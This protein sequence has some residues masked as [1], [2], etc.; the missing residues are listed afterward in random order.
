[1]SNARLNANDYWSCKAE[2]MTLLK[3]MTL[4][5]I[6][7]SI[8]LS[9]PYKF[10]KYEKCY[11]TFQIQT[12]NIQGQCILNSIIFLGCNR[13]HF[14]FLGEFMKDRR[15]WKF[16]WLPQKLWWINEFYKLLSMRNRWDQEYFTSYSGS[17]LRLMLAMY[18]VK[19][20]QWIGN[21]IL[22]LK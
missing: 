22:V 19:R 2:D 9:L 10:L 12:Q 6:C 15:K 7:S 18:T 4:I 8:S 21:Q 14:Y 13:F 20:L 3:F 16:K 17:Y 11:C 1:M 5:W